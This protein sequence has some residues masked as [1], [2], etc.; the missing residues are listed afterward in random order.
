VNDTYVANEMMPIRGQAPGFGTPLFRSRN[1]NHTFIQQLKKKGTIQRFQELEM[2]PQFIV[3]AIDPVKRKVNDE[4]LYGFFTEHRPL[5]GTKGELQIRLRSE[6]PELRHWPFIRHQVSKFIGDKDLVRQA[7]R[8]VRALFKEEGN[9]KAGPYSRY[10]SS[11][12]TGFA[13][14]HLDQIPTIRFDGFGY[15]M[16]SP[17]VASRHALDIVDPEEMRYMEELERA[18]LSRRPID[19]AFAHSGAFRTEILPSGIRAIYAACTLEGAIHESAYYLRRMMSELGNVKESAPF[20]ITRLH[21]KGDL[22]DLRAF[23]KDS[24]AEVLADPDS[25]Y[26]TRGQM[27]GRRLSQVQLSQGIIYPSLTFSGGES[28]CLFGSKIILSEE[29]VEGGELIV[30]ADGQTIWAR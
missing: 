10:S 13:T 1:S 7:E 12:D 22:H 18:T 28:V 19:D 6:F 11:G 25:E 9:E 20:R 16:S 30:H 17:R 14:P 15:R 8:E 29:I 5:W 21:I 27:L 2:H 23:T 3:T 4:A 24:L 26:L